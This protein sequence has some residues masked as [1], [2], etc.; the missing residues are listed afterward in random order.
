M[1]MFSSDGYKDSARNAVETGEFVYN[2]VSEHLADAMNE[3]S[4]PCPPEIDEFEALGL[5]KAICETVSAPR[6]ADAHAA[7]ECKVTG[8]SD[9]KD[10]DG[11][12]TGSL[13][14]IGQVTGVHINPRVVRDGRFDVE[15]ARPVTRLGY[16]DFGELGEINVKSRPSWN[17][18][19]HNP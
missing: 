8:M 15:L 19:K 2:Y 12:P 11:N 17:G 10:I 14:V 9:L 4:M 1:L 13:M 6:V 3:T 7:L 18:A 5:E 16:L